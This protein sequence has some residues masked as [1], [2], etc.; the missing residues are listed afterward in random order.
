M[1]AGDVAVSI[2][3]SGVVSAVSPVPA[4]DASGLVSGF[5][6]ATGAYLPLTCTLN[7]A[8]VGESMARILGVSLP[9]LSELALQAPA[10]C[11]G[12]VL[13]PYLEGERTP[14]VP[15][16]SGAFLGLN[17][18]NIQPAYLARA[19]MEGVT[20]GMNYGFDKI[21]FLAP[22]PAGSKV[23]GH[24]VVSAV[25]KKSPQQVVV[26]YAISVEIEGKPKPALAAEWLTVAFFG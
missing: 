7:G 2:G 10:G 16:G 17:G 20:M 15:L 22:V 25:E 9:Q 19:A 5:A 3:T 26:R 4:R 13:V 8:R 18:K 21:R 6:D 23:R 1:S 11:D 12:L 24:F 14:N